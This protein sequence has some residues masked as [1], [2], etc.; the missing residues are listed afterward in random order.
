MSEKP[1]NNIPP[2][3]VIFVHGFLDD[4]SVWDEAFSLLGDEFEFEAID[5]PGF[6]AQVD[7]PGPFTLNRFAAA[8]ADHID[9]ADVPAVLVGQ[10]MGAQVSELA[11]ALRPG[12]V[13]GLVLVT[14]VPLAGVH[15]TGEAAES[16]RSLGRDADAQRQGRLAV[17][18]ALSPQAIETLVAS[19][20]AA[21]PEVVAA[22]FDAWNAGDTAGLSPSAYLGPSLIVRGNSDPFVT[23]DVIR[24]GVLPRFENAKLVGIDGVGHFPHLENP[25]EVARLVCD[26]VRNVNRVDA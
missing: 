11:A 1:I 4:V 7:D 5:L 26:F 8:V 9:A 25:A 10:S 21:R 24:T 12:R 22:A 3:R 19:G 15:L 13:K 20:T 16:F 14:P 6:G 17:S 2:T 23:E 18:A